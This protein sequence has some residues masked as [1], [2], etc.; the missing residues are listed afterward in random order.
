MFNNL[1]QQMQE[2]A[3]EIKQKLDAT[4]LEG[5]AENELVKV[6]ITGNKKVISVEISDEIANDKE[7]IEDLVI[8]AINK[9]I[10]KAD[11]LAEKE[12]GSMA[13]GMLPDLGNIFGK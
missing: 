9:A 5:I 13:K 2:Q 11:K 12:T 3:S 7:A 6:K 4:I 1:M 10:E 8:V